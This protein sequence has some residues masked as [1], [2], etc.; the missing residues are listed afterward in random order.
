MRNSK[1]SAI[2]NLDYVSSSIRL[3][4]LKVI[5]IRYNFYLW[6]NYKISKFDWV[7]F[8]DLLKNF[9]NDYCLFSRKCTHG[10]VKL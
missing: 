2:L 8:G 4:M 1:K 10:S 9:K 5:Y 7:I 3:M 6:I